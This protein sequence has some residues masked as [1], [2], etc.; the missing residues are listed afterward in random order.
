MKLNPIVERDGETRI[1][2]MKGLELSKKQSLI[3]GFLLL[4]LIA[5]ID[6][7][8]LIPGIGYRSLHTGMAFGLAALGV[9]LLLRHLKLVSFGHA[10]FFGVS[11]YTIAV[12]VF[13]FGF[14]HV[15]PL[16]LVAVILGVTLA[17]VM[18]YF[19]ADYIGLYFALLTLAVNAILY[20]SVRRSAFFHRTDGLAVRAD[21]QRPTILGQQLS[22]E[23][24]ELAIHM[25][26]VVVLVGSLLFM[27]RLI[28]SPYGQALNAI[29][30]NRVRAEF[31]G[32]RTKN[33]VWGAFTISAVFASF[34]GALWVLYRLH[35]GPEQSLFVFR[36]GEMLFAV[37]IGGIHTLTGPII[38][39][40]ILIFLL[41]N[42]HVYTSYFNAIIGLLLIL[43]VFFFPN[44]VIGSID[45]INRE[46]KQLRRD[47]KQSI[48]RMQAH[49]HAVVLMWY[50][51]IRDIFSR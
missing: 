29:G 26:T 51:N 37:I 30:Q 36:S 34:G 19:I 4:L 10:A 2:V 28:N 22:T 16:I 6:L 31:I 23:L 18:G 5:A 47:P 43:I 50:R 8:R 42:I 44:G 48:R 20:Y 41:D 17:V 25:L 35:T 45:D 13:H 15:L 21:G 39:G 38:G 32:I 7:T 33:Y 46:V 9:N 14:Q 40:I 27:W 1:R 3:G 11:A 49:I 24:Y 12:L